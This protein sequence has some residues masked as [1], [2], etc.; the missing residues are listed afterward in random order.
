MPDALKQKPKSD[1]PPPRATGPARS[2]GAAT[3][4]SI[5]TGDPFLSIAA[6]HAILHQVGKVLGDAHEAGFVDGALSTRSI[7]ITPDGDATVT[8]AG[9]GARA[10][11]NVR[12]STD[13]PAVLAYA[14]P[15]VVRGE[16]ATPL[17]DQ[18]SLGAIAYE[19]LA[20]HRPFDG[21]PA[22]L[23]RAQLSKRP[24]PLSELHLVN[25]EEWSQAV[26]RMLE[27][28]PAERFSSVADAIEQITPPFGVKGDGHRRTL[29]WLAQQQISGTAPLV[30]PVAKQAR[31]ARK[32]RR[33]YVS[34][35]FAA[36]IVIAVGA[37]AWAGKLPSIARLSNSA[38]QLEQRL[39]PDQAPSPITTD[40]TPA[41]ADPSSGQASPPTTTPVFP[42]RP[43]FRD[44]P[45]PAARATPPRDARPVAASPAPA[46][47]T[48]PQPAVTQPAPTEPAVVTPPVSETPPVVATPTPPDRSPTVIASAPASSFPSGAPASVSSAPVATLTST[49]ADAAARTLFDQLRRNDLRAFRSTMV[50][51]RDDADFL[52]WLRGRSGDFQIGAPRTARTAPLPDGSVQLTYA[53]PVIWTHASGARRTRVAVLTASVRPSP[54]GGQLAS[55]VLSERFVP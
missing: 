55:W 14:S 42:P 6:V 36:L 48:N 18:Y 25:P 9:V 49:Q 13:D 12:M 29:G 15:E 16:P 39:V 35:G 23:R 28:S 20:G 8:I 10:I 1:T 31:E 11:P 2:R 40:A 50:A 30:E 17:S 7:F 37:A 46:T 51:S 47:I 38:T 4:E 21:S 24:E 5:L 27:K 53:V 45:I 43:V 3:L 22:K 52:D 19:L 33:R 54:S 41:L 34:W 26:M 44:T 32:A